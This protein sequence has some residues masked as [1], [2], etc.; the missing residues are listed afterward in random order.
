MYVPLKIARQNMK[1]FTYNT[2][3]YIITQYNTITAESQCNK[4][5]ITTKNNKTKT[6]T[7]KRSKINE[8]P[9]AGCMNAALLSCFP[10][11]LL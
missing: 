7:K 6:K 4:I 11:A 2:I 1:P 9:M 10:F 8:L 5:K 3:Q